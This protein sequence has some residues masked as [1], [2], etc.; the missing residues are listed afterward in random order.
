MTARGVGSTGAAAPATRARLS[1]RGPRG[2]R[3]AIVAIALVLLGTFAPARAPI[4]RAD[5]AGLD[6]TTAATYTLVPARH[7]VRVALDIT[8]TNNKPNLTAGGVVTRY[9]YEGARIAIQSGARNVAAS[10][11]GARLIATTTAADGYTVLEIRF[12]SSL[13]FQQTTR[14]RATFDLPGG[15]PRS[16]SDIRVGSA[17]A[18][19]VAWAFG[20]TGSVRVVVPAGFD[21]ATSGSAVT[22]TDAGTTRFEATGI[23]DIGG[24]YLVVNADRRSA[25]S[26]DRIDLSD[27]EHIVVR[28]WP[29]DA[30]WRRRVADLLTRS[31]PKLVERTGLAW[32]VSGDLSI[33][34]VHTPLLEGYGGVFLEGQDKIEISE[35]LDDLTIIH[36]AS[37]A[38]FNSGLFV[39]RWINEGLADTFAAATLG[40]L[41]EAAP[42]PPPVGPTD[43]AAVRLNAW[44]HPGRITDA[45]TDARERYGYS[46]SWTVIRAIAREIGGDALRRVLTA[47]HDHVI[48]Y[49]GAGV[50]ETVNGPNDWR[51]LLDLLDEVGGSATADAA[52][53]R[54]VVTDDQVALLD[55]RAA[56]RRDLAALRL[57]SGDWAAPVDVRSALSDW[58]FAT[59][60]RR[61]AD[62]RSV[63]DLRDAIAADAAALGIAPPADLRAAYETART[64]LGSAT[65]IANRERSAVAALAAARDAVQAPRSPL[66]ALGLLGMSPDSVLAAARTAFS[67]GDPD[68][69]ARAAAVTALIDGAS[70]VGRD[71]AIVAAVGLIAAVVLLVVAIRLVRR[72]RRRTRWARPA[73]G[74]S[75]GPVAASPPPYATLADQ[76][77]RPL[78]A[79]PPEPSSADRGDPS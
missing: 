72:R 57:A 42:K 50:P 32:P 1:G 49:G 51:R 78:D 40:D 76:S 17:F 67:A 30:T 11:A 36:E 23:T 77:R 48:A 54:W 29:E 12:G 68:A 22:R 47:A 73:A 71:R 14:I 62:A 75:A 18:T 34:E 39:G 43:A 28:A 27:G 60:R 20:D 26:A 44:V 37:H 9:F 31:L 33:F 38:W 21:A 7:V 59:A 8:A 52:F 15:A 53:R 24:W 58:D 5:S 74:P 45:T 56:A 64:D 19:F 63:L 3:L 66:V 2:A 35:D 16:T 70:A 25:L 69:G 46:A 61:I 13:F 79:D 6:L 41:G 55:D 4:A 65:D 10:S